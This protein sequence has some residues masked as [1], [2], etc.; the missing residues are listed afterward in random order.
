MY[1]SYM[2]G[3]LVIYAQKLCTQRPKSHCLET[4]FLDTSS[5]MLPVAGMF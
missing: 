1:I 5:V 4:A 3:E 2:V